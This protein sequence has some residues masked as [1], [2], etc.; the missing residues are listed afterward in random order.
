M[1]AGFHVEYDSRP[2]CEAPWSVIV[3]IR[4]TI[5]SVAD[6]FDEAG[7]SQ[8]ASGLRHLPIACSEG[9]LEQARVVS[10]FARAAGVQLTIVSGEC[11]SWADFLDSIESL[12]A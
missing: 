12:V 1:M 3:E 2:L 6:Q 8:E 7:K 5:E 10:D 11:P 4:K 9:S